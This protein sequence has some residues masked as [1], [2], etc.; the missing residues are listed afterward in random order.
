MRRTGTRGDLLSVVGGMENS[1]ATC[2]AILT[3]QW[4]LAILG[5]WCAHD[6]GLPRPRL[7]S[8]CFLQFAFLLSMGGRA[9]FSKFARQP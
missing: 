6:A 5:T 9:M 4:I 2:L 7:V 3:L 1:S 8:S